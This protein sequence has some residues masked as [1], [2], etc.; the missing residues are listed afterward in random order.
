MNLQSWMVDQMDKTDQ[1]L[2]ME[3]F[4]DVGVGATI[5]GDPD[6]EVVV[7]CDPCGALLLSGDAL[8]H[9]NWHERTDTK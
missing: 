1:Q 7:I 3:N 6:E 9:L 2:V 4:I 5:P 8:R